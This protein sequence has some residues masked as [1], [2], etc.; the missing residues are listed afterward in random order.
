MLA[1]LLVPVHP[2]LSC[3]HEHLALLLCTQLMMLLD[4]SPQLSPSEQLGDLFKG[5]G[6]NATALAC[7]QS[8]GATVKV[9]EGAAPCA[10]PDPLCCERLSMR[11]ASRLPWFCCSGDACGF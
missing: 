8:T 1:W 7:Y 9:V 3:R 5:A 4:L 6:D 2:L 10:S 11:S